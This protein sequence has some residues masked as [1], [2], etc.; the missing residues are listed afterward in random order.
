MPYTVT[1]STS[2]IIIKA[3]ELIL[4]N[5]LPITS[6]IIVIN[7]PKGMTSRT[8]V[9]YV[10]EW[11]SESVPTGH[12]G[13]LDPLASGVL[14]ICL[15]WTTRL[16][17]Y[18]QSMKKIY[19]TTIRLGAK[20]VTDDSEGP[21]EVLEVQQVPT[22]EEIQLALKTFEGVIEQT[23]PSHSA[24]WINGQRSYKLARMGEP[25]SLA[26]K[27]VHIHNIQIIEYNFPYLE[28]E[29]TCGKG[30]Y[31]RSIARDLGTLINTGGY[32]EDL[33]RTAIGC[34]KLSESQAPSPKP[35]D[36]KNIILPHE[37]A[38]D[39]EEKLILEPAL[40]NLLIKGTKTPFDLEKTSIN[41]TKPIAILDSDNKFRA[42]AIYDQTTKLLKPTK[43]FSLK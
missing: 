5:E 7:K 20:S 10:Q 4:L 2:F 19:K 29:I 12:A 16:V 40:L 3:G 42:M 23:P 38:V 26:P 33:Q 30:T 11:F 27:K 31:I 28:L 25:I 15:G 1:K 9:D 39:S 34:F 35:E 32:V 8:A 36:L 13:T 18:I 43:V 24:A 37:S 6:G 17:E 22:L 21:I 41:F 14:V